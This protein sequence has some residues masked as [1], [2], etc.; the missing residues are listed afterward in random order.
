MICN[1]LWREDM[2]EVSAAGEALSYVARRRSRHREGFPTQESTSCEESDSLR[3]RK[4]LSEAGTRRSTVATLCMEPFV[5]VVLMV[6]N[7]G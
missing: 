2:S 7:W 6:M 4:V 1:A 3:V 5:V